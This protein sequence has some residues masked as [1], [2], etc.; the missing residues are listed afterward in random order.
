MVKTNIY[1]NKKK[2]KKQTQKAELQVYSPYPL[3]QHLRLEVVYIVPMQG[4][5]ELSEG[6]I[7][8]YHQLHSLQ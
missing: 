5:T 3:Q 2:K 4:H 7:S 8:N 1:N 6:S